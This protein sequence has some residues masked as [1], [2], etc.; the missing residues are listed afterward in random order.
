MQNAALRAAGLDCAYVAFRVAPDQLESALGGLRALGFVGANLTIPHKETGF[1]LM[2][3]TS[4]EARSLGAVNTVVFTEER[5]VGHNTDVYGF[6]E[7]L[8]RDGVNLA[9]TRA[10]VL[11]A[12]GAARGVVY[13]LLREGAEVT[14]VNR[15]RERAALL[16][17]S[18]A[19]VLPNGSGPAA[20]G[21]GSS[22]AAEAVRKCELLVNATAAGMAPNV[23][24]LPPVEPEWIGPDTMVADLI[25]RPP[26]TALMRIAQDKGCRTMNGLPMLVHQ[27]AESLRLWLGIEPDLAAMEQAAA[28]ALANS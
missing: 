20:Y 10:V 22:D 24:D 26:V 25:Y 28:Q 6:L 23:D 17:E 15:N 8:R 18:M 9:G 2:S 1:R 3:E 13:G 19:S 14:I 12:G 27:G 7:P 16:A 21:A 11:G 4:D 5:M